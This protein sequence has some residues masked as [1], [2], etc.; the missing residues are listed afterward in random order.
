[1]QFPGGPL[2][3]YAGWRDPDRLSESQKYGI[4]WSMKTTLEIP[5]ELYRHAK[6][7][8]AQENRRI[9][10]LVSEGLALVLGMAE[11]GPSHRPRRMKKAPV[12][13]RKGNVIPALS[14]NAMA[15]LLER[16]GERLP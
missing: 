2:S 10:D 3:G 4:L 15:S 12:R 13:I 14:N 6:V 8:A 9:K 11:R 1:M 5:D 16:T 7:Q